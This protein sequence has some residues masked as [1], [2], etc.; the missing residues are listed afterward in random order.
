MKPVKIIPE[1]VLNNTTFM[2][3]DEAQLLEYV[4]IALGI[5]PTGKVILEEQNESSGDGGDG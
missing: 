2:A 4:T 3:F 1:F 5:S